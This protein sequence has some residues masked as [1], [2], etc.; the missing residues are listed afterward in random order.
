[1]ITAKRPGI[2]RPVG[3]RRAPWACFRQ[4]QRTALRAY[5]EARLRE[6][7]LCPTRRAE[8]PPDGR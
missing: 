7:L 2:E 4:R 6:R 3:R 8:S 1:M 5:V